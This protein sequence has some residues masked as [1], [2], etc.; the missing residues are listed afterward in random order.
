M[1]LKIAL[2]IDDV[3]AGFL[4]SYFKKYRQPKDDFEIT[5]NVYKLKR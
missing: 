2:D 3:L 4:D 1:T 5:R